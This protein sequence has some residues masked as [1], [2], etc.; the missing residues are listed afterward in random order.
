MLSSL[1][2][3]E[4][5]LGEVITLL[6]T[7]ENFTQE[8][9]TSLVDDWEKYREEWLQ[10]VDVESTRYTGWL[11]ESSRCQTILRKTEE[12]QKRAKS[13]VWMNRATVARQSPVNRDVASQ[14]S[15][16]HRDDAS[17]LLNRPCH[18]DT[19]AHD[20][21]YRMSGPPSKNPDENE[22]LAFDHKEDTA[23]FPMLSESDSISMFHSIDAEPTNPVSQGSSAAILEKE[24]A[25]NTN[26]DSHESSRPEVVQAQSQPVVAQP[27]YQVA[28]QRAESDPVVSTQQTS[29]TP[30]TNKKGMQEIRTPRRG[31]GSYFQ[32]QNTVSG[33]SITNSW[34][35]GVTLNTGGS[36]NAG[37]VI[38]KTIPTSPNF[39]P[40]FN[41]TEVNSSTVSE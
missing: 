11:W 24:M 28:T 2:R 32:E 25:F 30:V 35:D 4:A 34:A 37:P 21:S 10:V 26:G 3:A 27:K 9:R 33:I 22:S 40:Y 7:N 39:P 36:N 19:R 18:V 20:P 29:G 15:H 5:I 8:Q 17:A 14:A 12:L 31:E 41:R 38:N 16:N 23:C 1:Q 13:T 6:E